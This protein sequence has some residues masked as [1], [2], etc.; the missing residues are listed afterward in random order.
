F[1]RV[2]FRSWMEYK[3]SATT[4][5]GKKKSAIIGKDILNNEIS[6]RIFSLLKSKEI[7]SH[8]IERISSNE[9][10]VREV[11]IIPLEVVTRNIVAG[12]FAG[13]LGLEEGAVLNK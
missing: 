10:L 7:E 3:D 12:S 4:F 13:R 8:F 5:N 6:T 2:I 11:S 9:Q 1:R